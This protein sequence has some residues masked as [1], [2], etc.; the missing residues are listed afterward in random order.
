MPPIAAII[1]N[2]ACLLDDNSP[3]KNSL[4]ISKV[5]K[6]KKTA[7]KASLIQ[8]ITL[9]FIPKLLIPINK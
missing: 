6:K 8:C 9:N 1:G 5:T 7:I 2:S 4:L 3:C